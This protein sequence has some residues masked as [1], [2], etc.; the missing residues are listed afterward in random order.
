MITKTD[1]KESN[2]DIE[3]VDLQQLEAPDQHHPNFF[4][5]EL[6]RK[7]KLALF[8]SKKSPRTKEKRQKFFFWNPPGR[9][10]Y[11]KNLVFK[12]DCIILSYCCL[13]FFVKYLDQSNV[14]NAYVSGMKEALDMEGNMFN[15]LNQ[16][17]LLTYGIFGLF[18]SLLITKI[19]PHIV[20]PLFEVI[21]SVLC[22]LV[23]TC[24]TY[25]KLVA[26]RCL[27]GA[28]S[29]IVYPAC[30]YILGTWY[31]PAEL[32]AR[33][34]IFV[35]SGSLGTMFGGYIQSGIHKSLDGKAGLPGW[36]WIFV[37]DFL[38][39]IPVATFG[40]F[41]LPGEPSKPRA[42]RFLNDQDF[43]FCC[44]RIEVVENVETVNK[45]DFS[46]VKRA[47]F[48]WQLYVFVIA[49]VLSQLTEECTNYWNIVLQDQG[50]NIYNRNTYPTVQSAVKVVSSLIAGLYSG[51]RGKKWEIYVIICFF[52][53][54][55]L[56][57]LVKYDVPFGAQFYANS[58]LGVCAA[59]SVIIIS[60]ANEM[61]KEDDQLRAT[62]LGSLNF[63]F[64][65]LDVPYATPVFDTNNAPR[66]RLG[67]TI[68]LTFCCFLFLFNGVLVMFDRYQNRIRDLFDDK[69][70]KDIQ[71]EEI[72]SKDPEK[73]IIS[74]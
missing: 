30:H 61:C 6:T 49:Y 9:S 66:F 13:S 36:K 28:F 24:D 46:V 54:S 47:I 56:A 40:Y 67:M 62:V 18:G 45:F 37:I 14:N 70:N 3:S 21:W 23:I 22:L 55:G 48:S 35:S 58:V 7:Q 19:S 8:W 59:Y 43:E 74:H 69:F 41:I 60:W 50:F 31:T 72:I 63:I 29:G 53:I 38:I 71:V 44:K 51:I 1:K 15:W 17:F 52:W 25:P 68:G 4:E 2:I 27:Q 65:V 16:G 73:S 42:S 39:T 12:L 32:T 64:V 20:L 26:I 5:L 34:A 11:E 33:T 57:T 10:A